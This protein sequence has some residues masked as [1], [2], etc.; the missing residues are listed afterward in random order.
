MDQETYSKGKPS[1]FFFF[2]FFALNYMLSNKYSTQKKKRAKHYPK[3]V[4]ME[5]KG[6]MNHI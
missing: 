2:Y 4:D 3:G 1:N 6:K 5:N